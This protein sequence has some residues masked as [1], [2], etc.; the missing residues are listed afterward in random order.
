MKQDKEIDLFNDDFIE[1]PSKQ[2][3]ILI[4]EDNIEL[5]SFMT[6]KLNSSFS[7]EK[8]TNGAEAFDI[9]E[10]KNIDIVITDIMMPIM[11]GFELCKK[12]KTDIEYCHIPVVLLTAKNDLS[13]KIRGLETG[14]DAY[15]EKP[16]SFKYL[17]TQL[18]SLLENRKREKEAFI[19]KPYVTSHSIGLCKADEELINKIIGIIE[20][21]ITDSNF[22]VERLSEITNMSRSS[23]HRK[24]KALSGTSPTDF[25]RLIRLKKAS[26]LIAEGHYRTG[27]VCYIVGINSPSYF[28]KLFQK[29]FNMTPKEFEK[30]QRMTNTNDY[31]I[32]LTK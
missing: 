7:I 8:A 21:N 23:L 19:K 30:Q 5:L 1:P 17:I 26:E 25:I 2:E 29:Q 20:E 16:F 15:I 10:R 32:N 31:N 4:V 12:I 22:G 18:S 28:I 14:A 9:I 27:E 11:D 6:E 13:S 24:I 3:T